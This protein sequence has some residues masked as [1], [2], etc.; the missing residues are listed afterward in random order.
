VI[1]PCYNASSYIKDAIGSVLNQ[2]Y[3][4]IEI[5]VVNDGSTDET[6]KEILSLNSSK[7]RYF[8]SSNQGQS[9]ASNF[10]IGQSSGDFIKFFDADDLMHPMHI[11]NQ[12]KHL[13][14]EAS[15]LSC[16]S[17]ARFYDDDLSTAQF[18]PLKSWSSMDPLNWIKSNMSSTYDMM[19][20]WSWL[21]PRRLLEM[22]G[23]WKEDLTLNN[24][25]EFSVRL[26]LHATYV[27]FSQDAIMYYRSGRDQ[28]LSSK[29][30][31]HAYFSAYQSAKLGCSYI[32]ATENTDETR[33]LCANKFSYWLYRVYPFY[34]GL[35]TGFEQ[36]IKRLGGTNR[37]IDE[38]PL[39]HTIHRL[40]GWKVA[41]RLKMFCYR[42]GYARY[43]LWW[44]K[45]LFPPSISH[46]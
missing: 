16:C 20:A 29:I 7:I 23:G 46:R 14:E 32:L 22:A 39:M 36:E 44:K 34:P 25:F 21:I 26:V 31:E 35:V 24:D 41:K 17:W 13:G 19:P 1:I 28:S 9:A 2:T 12:L 43:I 11:E 30:S 3:S 45:Q 40:L 4:D 42:L 38:S 6:E 37:M 15:V 10:G 8:R 18:V 27:H 33:L 5:I